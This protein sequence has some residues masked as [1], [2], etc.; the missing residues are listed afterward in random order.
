[1]CGI[2]GVYNI[3][4][5]SQILRK[6]LHALQNRGTDATGIITLTGYEQF[7]FRSPKKSSDC[8]TQDVL[9]RLEGT[10]GIGH[11]RYATASNSASEK[12][13]Q[14][15]SLLVAGEPI[16]IAHNG[17]FTNCAELEET[18][19]KGT[20]FFSQSDT[21]R[22]FRL[23]LKHYREMD[24]VESI[25]LALQNM[26]GSCSAVITRPNE[27]IAVRDS[28]GNRPLYW[29]RLHNGYVVASESCALDDIGVYDFQE[30]PPGTLI[31]F[32]PQ[33]IQHLAL[34]E[35]EKRICSF[36]WLYFAFPSSTVSGIQ[37]AEF[38]RS[39]GCALNQ[40][41]GIQTD[42]IVAVPDSSTLIGE[43][44]AREKSWGAYDPSIITRKHDTGRT[45]IKSG[46]AA[47]RKAVEDKF[48][49][50]TDLIRGKSI[51]VIDD[52]VVRSTTSRGIT[53]SLR[54]RGA[55]AVH[56][57]IASPPIPGA[58]YYGINT[59]K[60]EDLIAARSNN[61]EMCREIGADSIEFLS[62]ERFKQTIDAHGVDSK[63]CCFACM[64]L[65]YW[66]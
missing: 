6:M 58:C 64:D 55:T 17:N 13:I 27:L 49:F 43:G 30:I 7:D 3:P 32:S 18:V 9:Q 1:M 26:K 4:D 51:T 59:P 19:L 62:L 25:S 15:L 37:V 31:S 11:N 54:D 47:R 46:E 20:P 35:T 63:N 24:F 8:L 65:Q 56:W 40:E 48:S 28:W 39:L 42:L 29:G 21:E 5:A 23:I 66:H 38:R 2:V 33:G 57:R 50:R 61:R 41:H 34:P 53:Q 60:R 52:S 16:S 22:F 45:F 14:P 12:N 44:Y 36:E 10:I